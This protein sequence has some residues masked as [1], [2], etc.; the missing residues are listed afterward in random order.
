MLHA[1]N[2]QHQPILLQQVMLPPAV[3]VKPINMTRSRLNRLASGFGG[4]PVA[5]HDDARSRT[6]CVVHILVL[7]G[8]GY[9]R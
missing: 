6:S 2:E 5:N 4:E 8:Q 9:P 1:V 3:A 7:S